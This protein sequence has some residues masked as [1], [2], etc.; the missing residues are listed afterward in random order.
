MISLKIMTI[1][2]AAKFDAIIETLLAMP[3]G[4]M[5]NAKMHHDSHA[6]WTTMPKRDPVPTR[7]LFS[8][9]TRTK[10]WVIA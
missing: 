8:Q 7:R 10:A 9:K 6:D 5:G 3:N 1:V 2:V 4:T